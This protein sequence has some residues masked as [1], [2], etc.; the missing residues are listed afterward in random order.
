MDS[1]A[2]QRDYYEILGVKRDATLDQIKSAYRKLARKY[3]PDVNKA[4]DA[5][6]K[7]REATEAYEVL[8]DPEKRRRYDQFGRSAF[9]GVGG[10]WGGFPPGAGGGQSIRVDFG[11]MDDLFGS[12]GFHSAF[13][14]MG[15]EELLEALGGH[16]R[17]KGAQRSQAAAPRG[18]D[19]EHH[20]ELD[21]LQ[22]VHGT[23]TT[24]RLT[25]R[26]ASGRTAAQTLAVK[27][28]P[29]VSEGQ[30]IRLRGKGQDGPG[31]PGDLLLICHVREHPYYR[32]VGN[33]IY[34]EVPVGI[35]EATL[36]GSVDVPTLDGMATIK[37]PPGTPSGR[38]IR[39]R[40]K[41]IKSAADGE[42]GDQYAVIKIVPPA[43][44]SEK[45]AALLRE[46]RLVEGRNA[47]PEVP[48]S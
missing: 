2:K 12:G 42:R 41:G 22:A 24:L 1:M 3:H 38:R 6:E 4:P 39:L 43:G 48:W 7:F 32:R 27:I 26:G 5:A 16:A 20:I 46:F 33:D 31:G 28:P 8:S 11:N 25:E 14:G 45:G 40:G 17:R 9:E 35:V 21:F 47:Q 23:T 15:L 13:M 34:V 36:G 44:V 10:E 29:G 18:A 30:K 37:I 19:I